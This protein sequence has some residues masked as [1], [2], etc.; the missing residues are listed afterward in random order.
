ML[1][2][3]NTVRNC[4]QN[5]KKWRCYPIFGDIHFPHEVLRL[6]H[7]KTG[8]NAKWVTNW[9]T[10][11]RDVDNYWHSKVRIDATKIWW[12]LIT[13]DN[14]SKTILIYP[15]ISWYIW[16]KWLFHLQK[17]PQICSIFKFAK[18]RYFRP[19]DIQGAEA[20]LRAAA[21]VVPSPWSNIFSSA[22]ICLEIFPS[23]ACRNHGLFH[24]IILAYFSHLRWLMTF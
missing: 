18:P 6:C 11:V 1:I 2:Q 14:M 23:M 4:E 8:F 19:S 20:S 13:S 16:A 12:H 17:Q 10:I 3:K 5:W 21:K 22:S 24:E 15:D 7:E 9:P